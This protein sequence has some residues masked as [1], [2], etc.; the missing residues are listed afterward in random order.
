[1]KNT[2][3]DILFEDNHLIAVNKPAGVLVQGDKT[4]DK[5]LIDMVKD[6][7][8]VEYKKPGDVYLGSPHRLDR[9]VSGIV[10]FTKTSK[11]LERMNALFRNKDIIKTYWAVVK[12]KPRIPSDKLV[13]Y[14]VKDTQKNISSAKDKPFDEGK[15]SEL[16]YRL[17]GSMN[18]HH[19]LE[20][21]PVTGRPHQIRVQL[22]TIGC[23][24]RGD[25]KYGFN[26]GNSDGSI[27]LHARKLEFIHPVKKTPTLI[28]A[29][30]PANAF[31]EQYLAFDNE[32]TDRDLKKIL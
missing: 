5:C 32:I 3:F 20:V 8:K 23:P 24:I 9:P 29:P 31:W 13:H 30:V 7:I 16:S 2:K 22:S 26:K 4:R 21:K 28:I 19:L 27:N 6:Y 14:L 17:L 12:R 15:R 10:I 25:V 18:D 1:M 11:A